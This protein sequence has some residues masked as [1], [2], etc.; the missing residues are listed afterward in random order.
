[1][2]CSI[3]RR[4][5]DIDLGPDDYKIRDP[6]SGRWHLPD[7]PKLARNYLVVLIVVLTLIFVTRAEGSRESLFGV[8][9]LFSFCAGIMFALWQKN[10]YY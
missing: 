4:M 1:M 6:K 7:D 8:T 10:K 5:P 9:A 3:L 2:R